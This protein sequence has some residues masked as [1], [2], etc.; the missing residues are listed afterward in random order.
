MME[1]MMQSTSHIGVSQKR[2]TLPIL[3]RVQCKLLQRPELREEVP[4]R[5]HHNMPEVHGSTWLDSVVGCDVGQWRHRRQTLQPC[6]VLMEGCAPLVHEN[7]G[8]TVGTTSLHCSWHRVLQ[9]TH[10]NLRCTCQASQVHVVP[11]DRGMHRVD[12]EAD[13]PQASAQAPVVVAAVQGGQLPREA[14]RG[15]AHEGAKFQG[16]LAREWS[17]AAE[18]A[19]Q[20]GGLGAAGDLQP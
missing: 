7:K 12:L 4:S 11:G 2:H 9:L 10:P 20:D 5:A 6:Q 3:N 19:G 15:V 13:T 18:G 17:P 8:Q 14:Q 1:H 16:D